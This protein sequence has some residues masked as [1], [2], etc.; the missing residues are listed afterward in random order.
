MSLKE[1]INKNN[2]TFNKRF[3]Q[4]FISDEALLKSI[5]DKAEIEGQTVVEIGVGGGTLTRA[6]ARRAKKVYGYEIDKR[7]QPILA[8]SLEGVENAE[9]IFKDFMREDMAALENACGGEYAVVANIPYYVTTPIIMRFID[10][11]TSCTRIVVM[12]Q[13]EVADR[14][15]AAPNTPDYGSITAAI[16]LMG[17]AEIIAVVGRSCFFPVPNVDSAVVRIDIERNKFK[18]VDREAFRSVL[19][20]AFQARRKT[21]ANNLMNAFNLDRNA[22]ES[23]IEMVGIEKNARGETLAAADFVKLSELL[24]QKGIIKR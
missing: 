22:A 20:A 5:V 14:L 24:L 19:R 12:V 15:S 2:F 9:I 21:L 23:V 1:I 10:E 8:E 13:K 6:I 11:A 18:G 17:S 3:G 7:L 4:N 16:E